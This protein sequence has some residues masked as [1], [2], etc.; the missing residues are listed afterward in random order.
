VHAGLSWLL[1]MWSGSV[2]VATPWLSLSPLRA[3][4]TVFAGSQD[5]RVVWPC[6]CLGHS[7][8]PTPDPDPEF[9]NRL[10][11]GWSAPHARFLPTLLNVA[12]LLPVSSILSHF[13]RTPRAHNGIC[14]L[15]LLSGCARRAL[16]AA[17]IPACMRPHDEG[18][19]ARRHPASWSASP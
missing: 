10:S 17:A 16:A 11:S 19:H 18:I 2:P 12:C 1:G 13:A 9:G 8:K 7:L 15:F 5:Y 4:P 3:S 6:T 14:R